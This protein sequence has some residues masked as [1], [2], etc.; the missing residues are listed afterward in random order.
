MNSLKFKSYFSCGQD[1][2]SRSQ[3]LPDP[4]S[5]CLSKVRSR[6]DAQWCWIGFPPVPFSLLPLHFV[7]L[8]AIIQVLRMAFCG[9]TD[10]SACCMSVYVVCNLEKLDPHSHDPDWRK[11]LAT[12]K[13]WF[14]TYYVIRPLISVLLSCPLHS[15]LAAGRGLWIILKNEVR[16]EIVSYYPI[17]PHLDWL[18]CCC[19]V[20]PVTVNT[21]TFESLETLY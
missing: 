21:Q 12:C 8:L 15:H 10:F 9:T 20:K 4:Q 18:T 14:S 16:E 2:N 1:Y 6:T 19:L 11:R 3:R 13:K 17:N 7:C 5:S